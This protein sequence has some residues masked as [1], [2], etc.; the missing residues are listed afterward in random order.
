MAS[1]SQLFMKR[2]NNEIKKLIASKEEL[3]KQGIFVSVDEDN[4][5]VIYVV[6]FGA[7]QTPYEFCPFFFKLEIPETYPHTSPKGTFITSDGQTRFNPNLYVNGKICLSILGTW[8]GPGWSSIMNI[9]TVIMSILGLVMNEYPLINEPGYETSSEIE[10]TAYN[11]YVEYNS[12]NYALCEQI[13]NINPE[14]EQFKTDINNRIL[15]SADKII[16]KIDKLIETNN[17]KPV[18]CRY[19]GVN[20]SF[21]YVKLKDKVINFIQ[22]LS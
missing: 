22:E 2:I 8:Q 12:L 4:I 5:K 21:D 19:C 20:T 13:K 7:E 18:V 3:E 1:S 17:L 10:K 15:K 6:I 16:A 14:F 9:T 11:Y